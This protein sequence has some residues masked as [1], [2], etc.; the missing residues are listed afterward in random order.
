MKSSHCGSVQMNLMRIHEDE[1]LIPGLAQW[2][3][4]WHCHE[5]WYRLQ[6]LPVSGV[7]VAVV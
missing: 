6:M 5:P 7:A 2:V 3:K 4:I 1:G